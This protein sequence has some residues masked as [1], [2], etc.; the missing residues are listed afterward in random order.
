MTFT[1]GYQKVSSYDLL[2]QTSK[3]QALMVSS[4]TATCRS[5]SYGNEFKYLVTRSSVMVGLYNR[6]DWVLDDGKARVRGWELNIWNV[7]MDRR[8]IQMPIVEYG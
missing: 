8:S 1:N 7:S 4:D 6:F 2:E 5:F 3:I